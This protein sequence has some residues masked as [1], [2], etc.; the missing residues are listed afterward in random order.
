MRVI[1]RPFVVLCLLVTAEGC[2]C[3]SLDELQDGLDGGS[4][5]LGAAGPGPGGGPNGGGPNGGGPSGGGGEGGGANGGGPN[6]GSGPGPGGGGA[7]GGAADVYPNCVLADGPAIYYRMDS[8]TMS[9]P[10]LGS[11]SGSATYFNSVIPA[12]SLTYPFA[13]L[14][15]KKFNPL[16]DLEEQTTQFLGGFEKVSIESWVRIGSTIPVAGGFRNI[17]ETGGLNVQIGIQPRLDT[18][19]S[20]QLYFSIENGDRLVFRNGDFIMQPS[21]IFHIV[22]VYRQSSVPPTTSDDMLLYVNGQP[23]G[24]LA[25][26]TQVSMGTMNTLRIAGTS[27]GSSASGAEIDEFAMYTYELTAADVARHYQAGT[28]GVCP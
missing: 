10:N 4:S 19:G 17:F 8:P 14:T 26:G 25:S 11:F 21:A 2:T 7:G 16:S 15:A 1:S 28:V 13:G 22:A 9:E 27:F 18:S 23:T 3:V 5:G 20:D 6:G 12:P 24:T